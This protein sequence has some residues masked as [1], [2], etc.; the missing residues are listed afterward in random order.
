MATKT[1]TTLVAVFRTTA[2]AEDAAEELQAVGVHRDQILV[3]STNAANV[4][5]P[6]SDPG[7]KY[8]EGGIKGWWHSIFGE[9]ENVN[10]RDAYEDAV[11][12]GN[13]LLSVDTTDKNESDVANILNRHKPINIHEEGPNSSTT[14]ATVE[15]VGNSIP[16]HITIPEETPRR[17]PPAP[18]STAARRGAGTAK[19]GNADTLPVTNEELKV[20][21]RRVLRGGVRV[22]SRVVE[23]PVEEKI[24]L[25]EEHVRVQRQKVDRPAAGTDLRPGQEQVFE[26]KEFAEVPLVSKQAR[27]VEEIRVNKG[28]TERVETVHE[29]VRHTKVDVQPIKGDQTGAETEGTVDPE[30]NA[31]FRRDYDA[32]YRSSGQPYDD[33]ANA[34]RFG[35]TM[36]NDP[37]YRDRRFEDV[38]SDLRM[39]YGRRNPNSVWERF[40]NSVH[41]GWNA[42][43]NRAR[44]QYAK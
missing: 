39:E 7:T 28:F 31:A 9:D 22:Y 8:R 2:E 44:G 33:Y 15:G 16:T 11:K 24:R 19:S 43:T 32:N 25:R 18:G 42:L 1:Q 13:V 27:V 4:Y 20:D 21:K 36:A 12:R 5:Q 26:V 17:E 3:T 34:Y 38:E 37:R 14:R 6:S 35:Y 41:Y 40:R 29:K 23:E 30:T 10:D